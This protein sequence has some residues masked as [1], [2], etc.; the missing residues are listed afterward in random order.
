MSIA[1][2]VSIYGNGIDLACA[3]KSFAVA[4]EQATLDATVLCN[5]GQSKSYELGFKSGTVTAEGVWKYD[6]TNA[7]EIH[8]ILSAALAN[9]AQVVLTAGYAAL[10]VGDPCT[11]TDGI[12]KTYGIQ[13]PL[14]QL[15][16]CSAE[17]E[18]DGGVSFG[19]WLFNAEVDTT[20]TN[21]TSV[22]NSASTANGGLF[23]V[24]Y[25]NGAGTEDLTAKIQHSANNST[26][27]DLGTI[28]LSNLTGFGASSLEIAAGTTVNRY[29][30]AQIA[31]AQGALNVQAAFARR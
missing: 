3:F 31:V 22:D 1:S 29:I 19:R 2:G 26:W 6:Q 12:V 24:H 25:Q 20:T 16:M 9:S 17:F 8:N 15:I 28:T 14:E 21:G 30:R 18:G 13:T 10:A 11:L 7:D 27:A 5:T 23:H 4:G